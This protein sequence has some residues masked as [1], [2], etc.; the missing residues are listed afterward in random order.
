[1][2][3]Y[4]WGKRKRGGGGMPG[5]ARWR[6]LGFSLIFTRGR[7]LGIWGNWEEESGEKVEMFIR[8]EFFSQ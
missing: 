3:M 5:I 8:D 1:M 4:V 6:I 2:N 7:I